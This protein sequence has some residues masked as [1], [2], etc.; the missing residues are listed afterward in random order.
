MANTKKL[1][2]RVALVTGSSRG[3][4]KGI[5]LAL[6]EAGATVYVTGRSTRLQTTRDDLAGTIEDTA[7]EVTARGGVGVAV[8]CDHTVEEDVKELYERIKKEQGTL[9]LLVNNAWGGYENYDDVD[10]LVPFWEQPMKRWDNMFN[11]GLRAQMVSSRCAMS[12]FFLEQNRGL[13][14]NTG[15][16]SDI[17]GNYPVNV[18]YDTVKR[19][20]V[21]MTRAMSLNLKDQHLEVT[22]LAL[23][24][25]WMRTE[26]VYKHYGLE[27]GDPDFMKIEDLHP[28]ESVEYIGRAVVA[29]ASDPLVHLQT[30]K[31][32]EVGTLA[33][34]YDFTD[35]DGRRMPPFRV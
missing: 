27:P 4:G 10:F 3:G 6:G 22:A 29:L 19:A 1:Q 26:A 2:G 33:E 21:T 17:G 11:A 9:D 28:T 7:D 18:F 13:I 15:V 8:R 25:G 24:P 12:T 20:V 30:G 34:T 5:A 35:T 14:I 32:L 31:L 23:A 16:Y